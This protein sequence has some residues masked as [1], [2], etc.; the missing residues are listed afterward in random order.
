[1]VEV[2]DGGLALLVDEPDVQY[3]WQKWIEKGRWKYSTGEPVDIKEEVNSMFNKAKENLANL[4]HE[5]KNALE[6]NERF[7]FPVSSIFSVY[8]MHILG[9]ILS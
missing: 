3:Y 1:M 9:L 5:L 7:Y 4:S 2:N 6:G 8:S